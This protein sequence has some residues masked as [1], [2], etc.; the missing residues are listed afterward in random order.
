MA[1]SDEREIKLL[2][3]SGH[4]PD[5]IV[6]AVRAHGFETD[7]ASVHEQRDI[8][9]DSARADFARRRSGLRVRVRAGERLVT[10]KGP[11]IAGEDVVTRV[12]IE[13]PWYG[14]DVP[15]RAADLPV[16]LRAHAEPLAYGR[17]LAE[18]ARI[19]TVRRAVALRDPAGG[20][21]AEL[22]IDDV[23]GQAQAGEVQRFHEIEIEIQQGGDGPWLG[24]AAALRE[25]FGF[26][27]SST[28]K[29]ERTLRHDSDAHPHADDDARVTLDMPFQ[30]AA[31]VVFR[32]HLA[33]L[34]DEEP[35]T[36]LRTHVERLHK[37]RVATRRLRASFR[38]FH[39]AF[40]TG[41]LDPWDALM[42]RTGRA[43]GPARDLDVLLEALPGMRETLPGAMWDDLQPF[44]ALVRELRARE[45]GNLLRWLTSAQR[46]R[47][48]ERF[49]AFLDRGPRGVVLS[50]GLRDVAPGLVLGAARRV[51]RKGAKITPDSPPEKVHALRIA[52]KRLRYTL[53]AFLDAYGKPLRSFVDDTK[54][55]QDLLGTYNDAIVHVAFVRDLVEKRGKSLPKNTVLAA[56]GVIGALSARGGE[57]R[58][59]FDEVWR[60]FERPETR[61]KLEEALTGRW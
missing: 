5:E 11:A 50:L 42:R 12:E 44:V 55:L 17:P 1:K 15:L 53:E 4:A 27:T 24:L 20:G 59:H 9:L 10:W 2:D 21:R 39:G 46:L 25:R 13:E 7:G 14:G 58:A 54:A 29:L 57:A 41:A 61:Q 8:Y 19:D 18:I 43:L 51:W 31:R 40:A 52:M 26:E 16:T 32:G 45:Q 6:A 36:R 30:E 48:F 23:A 49:D 35:G 60:A 56:G 47:G 33:R 3:A 28:S 37:M 38:T 22:A 34:R